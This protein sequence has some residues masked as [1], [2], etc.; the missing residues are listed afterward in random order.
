MCSAHVLRTSSHRTET[1]DKQAA[2]GADSLQPEM[3][4]M[5][6]DSVRRHL[7]CKPALA[8]EVNNLG[9]APEFDAFHEVLQHHAPAGTAA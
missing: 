5:T 2:G 1:A 3:G 7:V 9:L 8:G 4:C 6:T